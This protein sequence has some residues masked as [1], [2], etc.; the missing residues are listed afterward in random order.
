[1]GGIQDQVVDGVSGVLLADPLDLDAFARELGA[2]LEE[3]GRAA[4]L[5]R[6]ARETV[7]ERFLTLR[8]LRQYVDLFAAFAERKAA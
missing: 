8:H 1:V 4:G 2:L 7:R 5:G 3:P 6:E